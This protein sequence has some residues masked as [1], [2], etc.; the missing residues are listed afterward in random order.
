VNNFFEISICK[1]ENFLTGADGP[2]NDE[3]FRAKTGPHY[4]LVSSPA[5]LTAIPVPIV[6]GLRPFALRTSK[7]RLK[8]VPPKM[9]RKAAPFLCIEKPVRHCCR[10]G[11]CGLI[12]AFKRRLLSIGF[13]PDGKHLASLRVDDPLRHR[14]GNR[15]TKDQDIART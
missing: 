1:P 15:A 13:D 10:T 8:Q 2:Y 11:D 3:V 5:E 6:I 14:M 7:D 9:K 12:Q 4:Q